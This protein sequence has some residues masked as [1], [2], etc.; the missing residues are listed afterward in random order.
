MLPKDGGS[1]TSDTFVF[2]HNTTRCHNPEDPDLNIEIVSTNHTA[3]YAI[4]FGII[5]KVLS[6]CGVKLTNQV[7]LVQSL[8]IKG[9]KGKVVPA[10]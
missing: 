7:H 3:Y 1:M 6:D 9:K 10:L 8:V 4:C 5:S 2:Y